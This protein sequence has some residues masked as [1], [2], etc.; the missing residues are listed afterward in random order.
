LPLCLSF[1][2][3]AQ[4]RN[5][6]FLSRLPVILH[7]L[8][9]LGCPILCAFCEGWDVRRL[10]ATTTAVAFAVARI[11]QKPSSS[12]MA[13]KLSG[14]ARRA[15]FTRPKLFLTKFLSKIACQALWPR[16]NP[17]TPSPPALTPTK[18]SA[19]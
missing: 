19:H 3:A 5:L 12:P 2:S 6:P 13:G 1:R 10:R 14:E 18:K 8:Q 15:L 4:R 9:Q 16:K 17:L 11:Q 7:S